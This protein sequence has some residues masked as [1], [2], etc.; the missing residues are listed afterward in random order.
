MGLHKDC[1][2]GS[3][4]FRNQLGNFILINFTSFSF[5][6]LVLQKLKYE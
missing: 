4:Y 3:D 2:L 1:T 6:Y 5:K